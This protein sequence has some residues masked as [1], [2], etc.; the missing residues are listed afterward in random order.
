MAQINADKGKVKDEIDGKVKIKG[1]LPTDL[2]RLTQ[3]VKGEE[4]S[5]HE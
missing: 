5:S 4:R 3:I 1:W 2:H